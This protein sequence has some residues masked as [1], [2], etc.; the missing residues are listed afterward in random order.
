[1][2]SIAAII[3]IVLLT[4]A[5]FYLKSPLL[6]SVATMFAAIIAVLV[7]FN[8]YEI[9]AEQ[10]LS[11]GHGGQWAQPSCL[12]LLFVI[13][14]VLLRAACD[15]IVGANIEF[16]SIPKQIVAVVCGFVVGFIISG[17][18]IV[19]LAMSPLSPSMPYERF[20]IEGA[21]LNADRLGSNKSLMADGFVCGLFKLASK[22]SLSSK[23]SFDVYHADFLDQLHINRRNTGKER[24]EVPIIAG[25]KSIIVPSKNGVRIS[26][27]DFTIVRAGVKSGSIQK[28]GAA[29]GTNSISL[30]PGQFRLVCKKKAE[31]ADMQGSAIAIYP[32][33][34]QWASMAQRNPMDEDSKVDL[35]E[36]I[37]LDTRQFIAKAAGRAAWMDLVF[38]VPS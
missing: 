27:D 12:L 19:I 1:M 17:T 23:K 10:L 29:L 25:K 6:T 26:E 11:R 18:L 13:T 8:F 15:Q 36:N 28:D 32:L 5:Y 4:M 38:K 7:A 24:G 34:Y 30:T 14:L 9:V 21:K 33:Q 3:I 2:I 37:A 35:D 22:G 16:G 31:I 20:P